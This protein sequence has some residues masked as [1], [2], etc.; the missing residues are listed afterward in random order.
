MKMILNNMPNIKITAMCEISPERLD[1]AKECV[2]ELGGYTPYTTTDYHDLLTRED[3]DAVICATSWEAHIPIC[4]DCMLAGKPVGVEV[5]GAYSIDQCWELVKTQER[6]G[7]PFMFLENACFSKEVLTTLNMVKKGLFG[8][9]IHCSAGY[10]HDCRD[11]VALG[12]IHGHGRQRNFKRR[13][14]SLGG[15]LPGEARLKRN[16]ILLFW[17]CEGFGGGLYR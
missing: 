11:E 3:I 14:A 8:E 7:V 6:T 17:K 9:L 10:H 13:N 4:I 1:A 12:H 2:E 16:E 5:G 15:E